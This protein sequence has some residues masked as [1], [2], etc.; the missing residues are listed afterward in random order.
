[1][2]AVFELPTRIRTIDRRLTRSE[3]SA[4]IRRIDSV[5]SDLHERLDPCTLCPRSCAAHRLNGETGECGLGSELRLA[6]VACH[7]GEEPPVSGPTGAINVFFSGCNLHCIHCQNWPISQNRVGRILSQ[8]EIAARILK[9]WR[10]GAHSLGWVTPTP[11]IVAAL[12]A[13]RL[14]LLQGF[15]LPL[16]HNG[17]GYENPEVIRLLSGIVDIWL[18]DAKTADP[19]RGLMISGVVDY[20]ERNRRTIAAMLEQVEDGTSRALI[21]RHLILPGAL[22]D[23]K[24]VISLLWGSFQSRIH[25][26]LMAQYFPTYRAL[27]HETLGRR[28]S[29][30]EYESIVLYAEK[31]GFRNGWIQK[32]EVEN[33]IPLHCLP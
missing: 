33:G 26:S 8:E 2:E 32:Y 12:E 1:M 27:D 13:Y 5:L 19:Q 9:K 25:L 17:G 21:V 30:E 29:S 15:D 16:V 10:R 24:R 14:C 7:S 6:S 20:P 18:P 3:I 22:A 4:R 28:V 23:S 11:Q 31:L